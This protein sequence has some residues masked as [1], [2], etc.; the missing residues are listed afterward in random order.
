M[1]WGVAAAAVVGA[2]EQNQAAN[3]AA[4]ASKSAAS[5]ANAQLEQNYNR[6][7]QNLNPYIDAGSGALTG[8]NALASGDYSG[9]MNSPDYKFALDQGLQGVDRSAAARGSLYAGGHTADVLKFAGGL[10][11]QNLGNYRSSLMNLAQMGQ[12]AASNLGSI[13]TGNAAGIGNN[14]MSAANAQGAGY[15]NQANSTSNLLGQLAGAYGQYRGQNASS[16]APVT[17]NVPMATSTPYY[18]AESTSTYWPGQ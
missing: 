3:K 8:L 4:N 12:G 1:P 9:F 16:Y 6:T 2:V 13:G 11:S 7:A 5:Q 15:I 14:L 18:G 17:T 10:A